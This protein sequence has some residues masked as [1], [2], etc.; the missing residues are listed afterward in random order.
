[1]VITISGAV[2]VFAKPYKYM[3]GRSKDIDDLL[4]LAEK[5]SEQNKEIERYMA[6]NTRAVTTLL[7]HAL[8]GN[9]TGE[10]KASYTEL[11]DFH[12]KH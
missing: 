6:A 5:S 10:M 1:M 7:L 3:K 2:A 12:L 4:K 11:R 9:E 8:S